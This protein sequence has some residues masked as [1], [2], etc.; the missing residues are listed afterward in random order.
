[1]FRSLY[2]YA[3]PVI[4]LF[5]GV[6]VPGCAKEPVSGSRFLFDTK[7]TITVPASEKNAA[8]A[9]D[10]AFRRLE[11]I[12][13]KFNVTSP[14][15]P[16]YAFNHTGAPVTDPEVIAVAKFA[17]K[18]RGESE[19]AFE[20]R[21]YPLVCLWKFYSADPALPKPEAVR[22][23]LPLVTGK[24]TVTDTRITAGQKGVGLD[25]A[26]VISGYAADEAV[27]VLKS[28]GIKNALVDT[29]G[30]LYALGRNGDRKWRIGLKNPRG[31]G[32]VGVI[33]AE[34]EAVVTGGVYEKYF[35]VN[36]KRY[37]HVLD[38]RTGYPTEG[39]DSATIIGPSAMEADGWSTAFIVLGREKGFDKISAKPGYKAIAIGSD[40]KFY[41]SPE[42]EKQ[43]SKNK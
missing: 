15:S 36:G 18:V 25:L 34:N 5:F 39:I 31:E 28:D 30:E 6:L 40:D 43:F 23:T 12:H 4:A 42:A 10:H 20:P 9:I 22:K 37:H 24:V 2:K 3:V 33:E 26:G 14:S 38:P 17:F 11:E 35:E 8:R 7:C 16:L 21:I 13:K 32:V 1:M 19:G 41:L 29:G 27:R